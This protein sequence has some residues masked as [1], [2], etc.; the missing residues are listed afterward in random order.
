MERNAYTHLDPKRVLYKAEGTGRDTYISFN[1]GGF[2]TKNLVC[3]SGR[4]ATSS[5]NGSASS[6]FAK[7]LRYTSDGTGR[8]GYVTITDGGFHNLGPAHHYKSYLGS[9]R[10]YNT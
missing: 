7:S 2:T 8:D 10:I 6:Q 1:S 3:K 4:F 5:R 9:L